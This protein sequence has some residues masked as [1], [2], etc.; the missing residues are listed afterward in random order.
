M[1]PLSSGPTGGRLLPTGQE[2]CHRHRRDV[3][4]GALD[5]AASGHL[6]AT[7]ALHAF[8]A[9]C[10]PPLA[11]WAIETF[12]DPGDYVLDVMCG[13]GT[14]LVE[15]VLTGRHGWGADIDPLARLLA[16]AKAT[17]IAPE[18]VEALAAAI[19][20]AL[21][22]DLDD[23]W[24]PVLPDL[25]RW[26]RSEVS[27]DLAR[28]RAAILACTEDGPLRRL[29]W[30][31]F[32]S[33]IVARTSVANARDLVHSRHHYRGWDQDPDTTGRFLR[34]L[35]R[36][37]RLMADF[38]GRL[39]MVPGGLSAPRL[40][41]GEARALPVPAGYVDLVFF[42]PPYV[43]ALDYPRAHIFAVA[44]LADVLGTTTLAYRL[45][46]RD[47]IG[48][49]RAALARATKQQPL[50]APS[51]FAA[52]DSVVAELACV[53]AK[54]WVV[55][56][57]FTDMAAVFAECARVTRPGGHVVLVVCPSNI[58]RVRVATH[59]LFAAMAPAASGGRLVV[60]DTHERTIHDHRRV[61]PYLES[62]FGERMRTEYVLV[63]RR[64]P[65]RPSAQPGAGPGRARS[66][67]HA[68][69]GGGGVHRD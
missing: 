35:R 65:D 5:F 21:A 39:A 3:V 63:L 18:E 69:L 60:E 64:G 19:E 55:A 43:S 45:R 68:E 51:G 14:T 66:V 29:A 13:S 62:A 25:E 12:T 52:V 7:H 41:G 31:V 32:S 26:F 59:H 46:A 30:A 1:R 44:W 23:A 4:P 48:T 61:M 56:R 22:G 28:L 24:R 67:D 37:G 34:A 40:V 49:D 36:A 17:F 38:A 2:P 11:R 9:R 10:P 33:L 27:R 57:Y 20:Q 58:R 50:P 16:E 47:Y 53:P 15:A 6:Y 8:A 42:S 54:A